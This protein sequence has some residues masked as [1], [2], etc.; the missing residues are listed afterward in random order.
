MF[1]LV[2]GNVT[3]GT[4]DITFSSST[5]RSPPLGNRPEDKQ[6]DILDVLLTLV[7]ELALE[8]V[9]VLADVVEVVVVLLDA[10][11]EDDVRRRRRVANASRGDGDDVRPVFSLERHRRRRDAVP[12]CWNCCGA[13]E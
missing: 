12:V 13:R 10:V 5:V 6:V 2:V 9:V 7:L 8:Q 1:S 3:S 11:L 4:I